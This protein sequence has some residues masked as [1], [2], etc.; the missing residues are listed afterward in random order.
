M[1]APEVL[2]HSL[3]CCRAA[4]LMSSN[5]FLLQSAGEPVQLQQLE[6]QRQALLDKGD[7]E[8]ATRHEMQMLATLL[9][10]QFGQAHVDHQQDLVLLQV[11]L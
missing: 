3:L 10:S 9:K 4:L 7:A 5:V 2:W 1:A 8:T 11:R 6:A